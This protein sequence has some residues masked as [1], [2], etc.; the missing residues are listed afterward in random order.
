MDSG[1]AGKV[2]V[3]TGGARG[4]G[5][6]HALRLAAEGVDIVVCDL[7]GQLDSVRYPMAS[8]QDLDKTVELVDQLG[9]RCVPVVGDVRDTAAMQEVA[10]RAMAEFARI[11]IVLAN[12]GIMTISDNTGPPP[13][14]P[15]CFRIALRATALRPP[16]T[17]GTPAAP[18][19]RPQPT[20]AR[21]GRNK[22]S[23]SRP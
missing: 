11:D 15:G 6:S 5:R 16:W 2:A 9:R 3:I 1:L 13:R 19:S 18:G 20:P 4:Q 22:D 7:V 21:R 8:A 23:P 14:P 17:P 12:A 10:D